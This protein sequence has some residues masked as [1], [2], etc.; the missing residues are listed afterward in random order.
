MKLEVNLQ[1]SKKMG[2]IIVFE[3]MRG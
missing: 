1:I 2:Q 3:K